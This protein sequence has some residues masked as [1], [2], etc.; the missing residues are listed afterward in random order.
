MKCSK[1]VS[2]FCTYIGGGSKVGHSFLSGFQLI[3]TKKKSNSV[4]KSTEYFIPCICYCLLPDDV[5][6]KIKQMWLKWWVLLIIRNSFI[7]HQLLILQALLHDL[8]HFYLTSGTSTWRQYGTFTW[9]QTRLDDDSMAL[10]LDDI[11]TSVW[12]YTYLSNIK[13]PTYTF[14][15]GFQLLLIIPTIHA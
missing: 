2:R 4:K 12:W 8:R 11:M 5:T 7:L 1:G 9:R 3:F 15:C 13:S 10:L 6:D 14:G